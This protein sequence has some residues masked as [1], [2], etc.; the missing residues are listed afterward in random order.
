MNYEYRVSSV[1][2]PSPGSSVGPRRIDKIVIRGMSDAISDA[3]AT[4]RDHSSGRENACTS[5]AIDRPE[6][7]M[8]L[9]K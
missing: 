5:I 4:P 1:L 9:P 6:L 3:V 8:Y 2:S 7:Y